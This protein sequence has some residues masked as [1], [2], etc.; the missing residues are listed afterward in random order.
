MD[1]LAQLQ[2]AEHL[3][4]LAGGGHAAA[5]PHLL[6]G[7]C[8]GEVADAGPSA[9]RS[10]TIGLNEHVGE[11]M[12]LVVAECHARRNDIR[13]RGPANFL[14]LLRGFTRLAVGLFLELLFGFLGCFALLV[15]LAPRGERLGALA[16]PGCALALHECGANTST[17]FF[18]HV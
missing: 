9:G 15:R 2:E 4:L 7:K 16:L 5:H 13:L 3:A 12:R 6:P 17:S 8:G 14:Y 18:P 11:V 10:R 1:R